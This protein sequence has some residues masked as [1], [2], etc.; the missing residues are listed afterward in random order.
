MLTR[1]P[2]PF[3]FGSV[4]LFGSRAYPLSSV[5]LGQPPS[6]PAYSVLFVR[7]FRRAQSCRFGRIWAMQIGTRLGSRHRLVD[8]VEPSCKSPRVLARR[9]ATLQPPGATARPSRRMSTHQQG[10]GP[11]QIR[12]GVAL[13]AMLG[14]AVG[15]GARAEVDGSGEDSG[16]AGTRADGEAG[17]DSRNGNGGARSAP[18]PSDSRNSID[19]VGMTLPACQPGSLPFGAGARECNYLFDGRCHDEA[20]DACACACTGA[21]RKCIISGFLN[22][23]EPQS[24]TCIAD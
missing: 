7:P 24:V 15:C 5:S 23:D 3:G 6:L 2:S 10:R 21:A 12:A 22:P 20:L 11:R 4:L 1:G 18:S 16:R 8:S 19:L 17:S 9:V 13:I 14:V